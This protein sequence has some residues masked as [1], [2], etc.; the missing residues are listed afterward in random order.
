MKYIFIIVL[1]VI[2]VNLLADKLSYRIDITEDH[3]HTLSSQTVKQIENAEGKIF[4]TLFFEGELP[5]TL[6][7]LKQVVRDM[8]TEMQ[9]VGNGKVEIEYVNPL[10]MAEKSSPQEVYRHLREQGIVPF[11]YQEQNK[12]GSIKQNEVYPSAIIAY[13]DKQI[14]V[15][16]LKTQGSVN[17]EEEINL[18]T[19]KVEYEISN[20]L[21]IL[22][23][24]R[25]KNIAFIAGH[26]ELNYLHTAD[27]IKELRKS[28][29]VVNLTIN[30]NVNALDTFDVAVIAK[31]TTAWNESDKFIVDQ[32][33]MK[34]G[35]VA[36]FLDAV[37][38]HADSLSSGSS[39]F[40]FF[41]S[42]NLEDILFKYGIRITPTVI[43][44]LQCVFVPVNT[45][46]PGERPKFSPVPWTYYPL[47]NATT[48]A[49]VK[50]TNLIK[51]EFPSKIDTLASVKNRKSILLTSSGRANI[52]KVPAFISL[53][54]IEQKIDPQ[55]FQFADLPVGV[56]IEGELTSAFQNR[57]ISEYTKHQP[58]TFTSQTSNARIV[59]IADGDIIANDVRA[60]GSVYPLGYD[61]Y[62]KQLLYGNADFVKNLMSYLADEDEVRTLRN[63][64]FAYRFFDKVKV[65]QY[66]T[67]LQWITFIAPLLCILL[68]QFSYRL[69][70]VRKYGRKK[71]S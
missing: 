8:L 2:V 9:R 40:G 32:F 30:G 28:Y 18:S 54:E 20:A 61:K 43:Q 50:G 49:A 42:V 68:L 67:I 45:A 33:V 57:N 21:S 17:P 60:D 22:L 16:F 51:A 58:F 39:T 71:V 29:K 14:A 62:A 1:S 12:D 13:K 27:I 38:V 26:G 10:E 63:R 52:K 36:F 44:D 3:R 48:H 23:A 34:G 56:L 11:T 24:N 59:V 41:N 64:T 19:G 65:V 47:L 31:P 37:H 7:R 25:Q 53:R 69:Y 55:Q 6:L 4:I 66:K 5:F 15:N 70:R 46:L 35:K